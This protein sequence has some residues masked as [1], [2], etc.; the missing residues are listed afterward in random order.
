MRIVSIMLFVLMLFSCA[1]NPQTAEGQIERAKKKGKV[2]LV[3]IGA[4]SCTPCVEMKAILQRVREDYT[5]KIIIIDVNAERE[6][7][8][9][10]RLGIS[11]IPTQ[12]F[13]D[14]KGEEY[15]RH[16]GYYSYEEIAYVLKGM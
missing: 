10:E 16:E 11:T 12:I 4:D 5:E 14:K 7:A 9:I 3:Q 1:Q 8:L 15:G 13:L 6:K 2:V